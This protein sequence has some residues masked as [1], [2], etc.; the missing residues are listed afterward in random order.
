[1]HFKDVSPNKLNKGTQRYLNPRVRTNL[2]LNKTCR[3]LSLKEGES[4]KCLVEL[5]FCTVDDL[6]PIYIYIYIYKYIYIYIYIYINIYVTKNVLQMAIPLLVPA[7]SEGAQFGWSTTQVVCLWM[8]EWSKSS[9]SP[10]RWKDSDRSLAGVTGA[11][12]R[13]YK[14]RVCECWSE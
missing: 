6:I 7:Y 13:V 10:M 14:V 12:V 11:S 3:F 8:S 4:R 9:P 5:V 2:K 1:M